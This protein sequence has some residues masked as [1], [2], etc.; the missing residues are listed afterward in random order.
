MNS[1]SGPKLDKNTASSTQKSDASI[2]IKQF[3]FNVTNVNK[4]FAIAIKINANDNLDY[5]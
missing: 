2:L 4:L 5:F 1:Y 3:L